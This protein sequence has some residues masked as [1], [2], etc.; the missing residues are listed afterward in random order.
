MHKCFSLPSGVWLHGYVQHRHPLRYTIRHITH[1]AA[2]SESLL[3]HYWRQSD[4]QILVLP[5]S[6]YVSG[7]LGAPGMSDDINT[8]RLL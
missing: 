3:V 7:P 2:E 8:A 1:S 6:S 4:L 5:P